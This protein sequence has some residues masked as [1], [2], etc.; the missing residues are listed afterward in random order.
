MLNSLQ[1]TEC[2]S[3]LHNI[4]PSDVKVYGI[5]TKYTV[6]PWKR[7]ALLSCVRLFGIPWTVAHQDTV[8]GSFHARIL[9][10][11]AI[12]FSRSLASPALAG[13]FFTT[14]AT[15]EALLRVKSKK[16]KAWNDSAVE[17]RIAHDERISVRIKVSGQWGSLVVKTYRLWVRLPV[18]RSFLLC[19]QSASPCQLFVT[20]WSVA[21]QDPL[22]MGFSRQGY[23]RG[24]PSP[25]PGDLPDPR[26]KLRSPVWQVDFL[27]LNHLRN[28]RSFLAS[29]FW[30][31]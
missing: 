13:G 27:P 6:C 24:L 5:H 10:W 9:E 23:W 22:C 4:Y 11:V 15:W 12:S 16:S 8:H 29:L 14:S 31:T 20:P 19:A 21:H 2:H 28:P 30:A 25:S 7:A 18:S 17:A 1:R 3:R 26:V